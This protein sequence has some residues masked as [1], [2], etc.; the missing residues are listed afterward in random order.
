VARYTEHGAPTPAALEA[1]AAL[2][3]RYKR[4]VEATKIHAVIIVRIYDGDKAKLTL[5]ELEQ[6]IQYMRY[7]GVRRI[8]LYDNWQ[9]PGES[10]EKW[11][12]ATK[13][14][15]IYHDWGKKP[16]GRV[17]YDKGGGARVFGEFKPAYEAAFEHALKYYG[18]D[19]QWQVAFDM[20][21]Y[22]ITPQ[23]LEPGALCRAVAT[24][25]AT[26]PD[27]SELSLKNFVVVGPNDKSVPWIMECGAASRRRGV[28]AGVIAAS[29]RHT[30]RSRAGATRA[31]RRTP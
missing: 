26:H 6:W 29:S 12:E 10:L 11:A 31:K 17:A 30:R 9:E 21:E 16:V 23:D 7:V 22:P 1:D 27:V 2:W 8:Y 28:V 20:D 25:R 4:D 15:V 5:P 3:A 18:G 19:S 13:E 14:P 24:F